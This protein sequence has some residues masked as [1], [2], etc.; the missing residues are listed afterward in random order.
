M[1]CL[2]TFNERM[3]AFDSKEVLPESKTSRLIWATEETNK[4]ILPTDQGL[5]LWRF[6]ETPTYKK[7]RKA[8]EYMESVAIE[9]VHQRK[10]SSKGHMLRKSLVEEYL[11]NPKLDL[12]DVIGMCMDLMLAGVDTTSYTLAF[13]LYHISQN[14][15]VQRR[16]FEESIKVLKHHDQE[17]S[18][19]DVESKISYTRAVLKEVFRLNP[20][21]V[22]VGRIISKDMV[23]GGYN[24]PAGV[25]YLCLTLSF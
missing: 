11:K 7:I 17:L 4:Y 20:I 1:T 24:V 6:F 14:P 9:L 13:A 15:N 23:L 18:A 10:M 25:S 3:K 21:S 2:L 16:M 12:S 19:D 5:Q 22:G 8:Q